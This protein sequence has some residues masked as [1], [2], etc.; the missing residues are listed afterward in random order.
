MVFSLLGTMAPQAA[1]AAP[2]PP[3]KTARVN[4][5]DWDAGTAAAPVPVKSGDTIEY[6]ITADAPPAGIPMMMQGNSDDGPDASWWN[7]DTGIAPGNSTTPAIQKSQVA[8][9]TFVNLSTYLTPDTAVA[10]FLAAYPSWNSKPV[11][12]AWDAT[13]SDTS[14]NPDY[15]AQRVVAWATAGDTTG[16]YDIY[17]GGQGGIW[18]SAS[19]NASH[20]FDSFTSATSI[21]FTNFHTNKAVNMSFMFANFAS[22]STAPSVFDLTHFDTSQVTDMSHMFDH[23]AALPN[24]DLTHFDTSKVTDMSFMFEGFAYGSMTPPTLDLTHF[25]TSNVT[26]MRAM[27]ND[28]AF[29]STTPPTLNLTHFDTSQVTDMSSMF[30]NFAISSTTPPT[31]DLTHFNTAQVTDMSHMFYGFSDTPATAVP[32]LDLSAFDTSNVTNMSYMF[33]NYATGA[34]ISMPNPGLSPNLNLSTFNTAKVTDMSHMFDR[35][36]PIFTTR[37]TL[38]LRWFEIGVAGGGTDVSSMFSSS[39]CLTGLRLDSGVF[40]SAT[41][42]GSDAMFNG[43]RTDLAV[44]VGTTSDQDWMEGLAQPPLGVI[45]VAGAPSGTQPQPADWRSGWVAPTPPEQTP[46][47]PV[48]DADAQT[49]IAD[50]IPDGLSIDAATITGTE[51]ATPADDAITWQRSGQTIT[52]SVPN[53][54][55]PADVTVTVAVGAVSSA[56]P[57]GTVFK[58]TA[59]VVA[60]AT[61]STYH[62]LEGTVG[63]VAT[64][65]NY[66]VEHYWV[67]AKGVATLHKSEGFSGTVGDLAIALPEVYANYTYCPGYS[68]G[69]DT[70]VTTGTIAA[71]GSLVLKLYYQANSVPKPPVVK[72]KVIPLPQTGDGALLISQVVLVY[73]GALLALVLWRRR[74][75]LQ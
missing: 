67:D 34:V 7:Q 72:P 65:A 12:E 37:F 28:Y 3:V 13:E 41:I 59:L 8:T 43:V 24:L 18:M 50:T 35:F 33:A 31:L 49:A 51:S 15:D 75:R 40:S 56:L 14:A 63:P 45:T 32:I 25:D 11:L 71:D 46:S 10:Q 64:L 66:T 52:W 74:A 27:F 70:E 69:S 61:N 1:P 17:V 23:S 53:S 20:L 6:K 26:S 5:G 42:T 21:D 55:L 60:D 62:V 47:Q 9:I 58:N 29:Y 38:D 16:Q 4:G 30:T 68:H 44:F 73:G 2:L 22:S 36:A 57:A 19:P 54:M 39:Q 48:T